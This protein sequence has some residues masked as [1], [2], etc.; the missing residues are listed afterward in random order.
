MTLGSC[1]DF[2]TTSYFCT[3]NSL[4]LKSKYDSK[5]L[6]PWKAGLLKAFQSFKLPEGRYFCIFWPPKSSVQLRTSE[7]GVR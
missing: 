7:G 5:L 2:I 6:K 3:R 1:E 4:S